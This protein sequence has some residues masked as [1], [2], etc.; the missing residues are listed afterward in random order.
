MEINS[1]HEHWAVVTLL[2]E[3]FDDIFIDIVLDSLQDG[4]NIQFVLLCKV[5][6]E[7]LWLVFFISYFDFWLFQKIT[8]KNRLPKLLA[9]Q[10]CVL[11]FL[12]HH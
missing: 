4:Q 12:R 3:L 8:L 2:A 10:G 6:V 7:N 9:F 5:L 11:C 1:D